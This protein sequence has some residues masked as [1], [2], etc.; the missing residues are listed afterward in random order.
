MCT[1]KLILHDQMCFPETKTILQT[2]EMFRKII[3]EE[4]H[5]QETILTKIPNFNLVTQIPFEYMASS[6]LKS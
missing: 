2:D 1:K 4:Y 3:I 5:L 6:L